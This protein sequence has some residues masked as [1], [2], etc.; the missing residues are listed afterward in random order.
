M[1]KKYAPT[2]RDL[3]MVKHK[4]IDLAPSARDY[5][6]VKRKAKGGVTAAYESATGWFKGKEATPGREERKNEE[7]EEAMFRNLD[8]N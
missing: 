8:K 4:V 3:S 2:A 1:L 6:L 5:S 7:E